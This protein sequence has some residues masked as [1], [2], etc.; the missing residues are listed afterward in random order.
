MIRQTGP[1]EKLV[2][3]TVSF[4][5]VRV[6]YTPGVLSASRKLPWVDFWR[7]VE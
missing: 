6:R 3:D 5:L 4:F 1:S 7:R 2:Y